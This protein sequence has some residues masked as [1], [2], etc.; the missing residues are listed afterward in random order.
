MTEYLDLEDLLAIH[1]AITGDDAVRDY[2]LLQSAAARPATTVFGEPAYATIWEQAA[3]LLESLARN[4]AFID[5]NKR[6]AW[7]ATWTFLGI[8]GHTLD[9]GFDQH[10][11]EELVLVVAQGHI[12]LNAVASELVKYERR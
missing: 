2:G 5:G 6:T 1:A 9:V 4:H 8:N 10:T 3:A 11:A 7:T 12:G